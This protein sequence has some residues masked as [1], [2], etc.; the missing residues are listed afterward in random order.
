MSK[1][2]D[3]TLTSTQLQYIEMQYKSGAYKLERMW[4][5]DYVFQ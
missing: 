1:V 3:A 2:G 4:K 5:G